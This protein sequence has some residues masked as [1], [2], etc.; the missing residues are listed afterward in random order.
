[1]IIGPELVEKVLSGSIAVIQEYI[2]EPPVEKELAVQFTHLMRA[3][4]DLAVQT[5]TK[6][7][8]TEIGLITFNWIRFGNPLVGDSVMLII[9]PRLF[10]ALISLNLAQEAASLSD[11]INE[12]SPTLQAVMETDMAEPLELSFAPINWWLGQHDRTLK[13]IRRVQELI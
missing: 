10:D 2:R 11:L 9:L 13:S 1:S 8:V 12:E 5:Q 3:V 6:R 7:F 4:F